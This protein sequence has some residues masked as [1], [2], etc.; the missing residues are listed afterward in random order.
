M[1]CGRCLFISCV[2]RYTTTWRYAFILYR[3]SQCF[4]GVR[5]RKKKK[6]RSIV[7]GFLCP[8]R[9]TKFSRLRPMG[10]FLSFQSFSRQAVFMF[11]TRSL[12]RDN[13]DDDNNELSSYVS[14]AI[15][16]GTFNQRPFKWHYCYRNVCRIPS[17]NPEMFP[18]SGTRKRCVCGRCKKV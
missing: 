5:L 15:K 14:I 1:F 6:K 16:L 18:D 17:N 10:F 4:C 13:D 2:G 7:R 9:R 3:R 12:C 8:S 11:F